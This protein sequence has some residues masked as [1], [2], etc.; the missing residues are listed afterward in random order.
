MSNKF[1]FH[2][3]TQEKRFSGYGTTCFNAAVA[4][5]GQS[6]A[7]RLAHNTTQTKY[8]NN[9]ELVGGNEEGV[10]MFISRNGITIA[11]VTRLV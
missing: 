9:G 5:L 2:V 10:S 8:F 6:R 7:E 11:S 3:D 1:Y 4:T